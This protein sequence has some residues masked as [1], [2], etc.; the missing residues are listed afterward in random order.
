M[1]VRRDRTIKSGWWQP[2]MTTVVAVFALTSIV[3]MQR[4]QLAQ[5]SLWVSN[6]KQAEQQEAVRLELLKLS[7]TFG[8]SNLVADGTFLNFLQYYGDTAIREQTGYSLSPDYFDVITR[9]DPRFMGVSLFISG[10]VSYQLGKPE[11]AIQLLNRMTTD[12]RAP[13]PLQYGNFTLYL[14]DPVSAALP[15]QVHPAAFQPWRF[16]GIDQLLL[17]GD[18][19][20]SIHSHEMAAQWVKGTPYEEFAP[21]FLGTAEF[22]RRDPNNVP[23]RFQAWESV[24]YQA[25]ASRDKRTQER[26]KREIRALGGEIREENGETSFFLPPSK[27]P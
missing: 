27:S 13:Q 7:P 1:A 18:I 17:L 21:L 23:V 14:R 22:I 19:P 15:P 9:L 4:S 8:F 11:L 5:P 20:G 12:A 24:Y 26:A 25:V 10:S 16:K 3:M 6:P 2:L